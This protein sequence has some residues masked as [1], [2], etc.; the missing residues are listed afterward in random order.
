MAPEMLDDENPAGSSKETDVYAFGIT[1]YEV[2][3]NCRD[4]WVTKDGQPMRD[5]VIE[6]Q[7]CKGNRPNRIDGIPDDIWTLIEQCWHQEP[8]ERPN[9]KAILAALEPYRDFRPEPAVISTQLLNVD[10]GLAS[11]I[12]VVN[13]NPQVQALPQQL[14]EEDWTDDESI[15]EYDE[16]AIEYDSI[17]SEM[18][19]SMIRD[20]KAN[21]PKAM[22]EIAHIL[23]NNN[24]DRKHSDW[25]VILQ[26]FHT[27]ALSDS[28]DAR[29]HLG[30][31]YLMDLGVDKSDRNV[32]VH[33]NEVRTKSKDPYFLPVA[34]YMLGWFHMLGRGIRRDPAKGMELISQCKTKEFTVGEVSRTT[35]TTKFYQL[36]QMGAPVDPLCK[37]LVDICSATGF[38]TS[39]TP[40][41]SEALYTSLLTRNEPVTRHL[42]GATL[43]VGWGDQTNLSK[44]WL[45]A[46]HST[47]S[48]ASLNSSC[49]KV[50][51]PLYFRLAET[52]FLEALYHLGWMHFIG[53]GVEKNDRYALLYWQDVRNKSNDV[54]LTRVSTFMLAM[55]HY[56][57]RGTKADRWKSIELLKA[58]GVCSPWY[59]ALE[60]LVTDPANPSLSP[61]RTRSAFYTYCAIGSQSD[62]LCTF[63]QS[64]CQWTGFIF[65]TST[66]TTKNNFQ[67]LAKQG[68]VHAQFWLGQCNAN[69]VRG[70]L[71]SNIMP[72]SYPAALTLYHQAANQ[73]YPWAYNQLGYHY[74]NG[75]GVPEDPSQAA[76]W[77]RKAAEMGVSK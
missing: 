34:T 45:A 12:R 25:K 60:S 5:R 73:G 28:D 11:A 32:F 76:E 41:I 43:W 18:L 52:G 10:E 37:Y 57:G 49:W 46:A 30:I 2:L 38:G 72:Q 15:V 23:F 9:F 66:F 22:L 65:E 54:Y 6:S 8:Q 64:L 35:E 61:T 56:D 4:I 29:F 21:D 14:T 27:L 55:L 75:N 13:L 62:I 20:A 40:I 68:Y 77:Y 42:D 36:C 33:W 7:V 17:Q 26:I 58:A 3:N 67:D 70:P 50:V 44:L 47:S 53:L 51:T 71:G 24:L 1:M 74:E 31:I 16:N 59:I 69:R 39:N 48:N 19:P 63:L